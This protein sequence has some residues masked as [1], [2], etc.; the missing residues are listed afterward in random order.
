[1]DLKRIR[2][3]IVAGLFAWAGAVVTAAVEGGTPTTGEGWLALVSGA[4]GVGVLTALAT[5][6]ARNVGRGLNDAGSEPAPV[7][8]PGL[9][10]SHGVTYDTGRSDG[11]GRSGYGLTRETR[12]PPSDV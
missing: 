6:K 1:M 11:T 9:M 10:R 12:R 2:K 8:G 5:Y 4:A 7:Q 3:A